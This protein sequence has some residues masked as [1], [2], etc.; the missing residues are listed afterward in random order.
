MTG[1]WPCRR[2]TS[3]MAHPLVPPFPDGLERAVF[4]LGCFWGAE[5]RFWQV[6]GV[7]T[8]AVG[9]AGGSTPNPTYEEVCS[10][11]HR[12]RRGRAGRVRPAVVEYDELLKVFWDARPDPGH[13][14]GQR[15]R[16]AVPVGDLHAS[17]TSSA[18]WRSVARDVPG[19]LRGRVRGRSRRRSCPRGPFYYAEDYHQ[20]YLAKVPTATAAWEVPAYLPGGAGRGRLRHAF[21]GDHRHRGHDEQRHTSITLRLAAVIRG[22]SKKRTSSSGSGT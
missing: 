1:P 17:T 18:T 4:G 5:R 9:Y 16:H 20:Q 12:T 15:C 13:A 14:A 2:P 3:S 11:L 22:F 10:G 7:F 8:T 6:E 21:S 19:G